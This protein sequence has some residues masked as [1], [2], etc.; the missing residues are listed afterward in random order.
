MSGGLVEVEAVVDVRWSDVVESFVGMREQL[1][2][3]SFLQC[4]PVEYVEMW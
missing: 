2:F 4:E 1:E 3:A